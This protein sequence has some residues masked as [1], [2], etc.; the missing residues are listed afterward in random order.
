MSS[1]KK[2][3]KKTAKGK[4]KKAAK[5]SPG[6]EALLPDGVELPE[7]FDLDDA[8]L[9]SL[10]EG[11]GLANILDAAFDAPEN[12]RDAVLGDVDFD[13]LAPDGQ[14]LVL[15][16]E[17]FDKT[18][19]N[20]GWDFQGEAA[21]AGM[22]LWEFPP[23]VDK[24]FEG[25][26]DEAPMTMLALAIPEQ[27]VPSEQL[28][29]SVSLVGEDPQLP[30]VALL[31]DV[32]KHIRDI[33]HFRVGGDVSVFPFERLQLTVRELVGQAIATGNTDLLPPEAGPVFNRL[34]EF[35]MGL[36]KRGWALD[37]DQVEYGQF[38]WFYAPS[39]TGDDDPNIAPVTAF[40]LDL[41]DDGQGEIA[42]MGGILDWAGG[43]L[44][45][46][47]DVPVRV[48]RANLDAVEKHRAGDP[49]PELPRG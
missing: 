18:L 10:L 47:E 49:E 27:I 5:P 42:D 34:R 12:V 21:Y 7:N 40:E 39:D 26:A 8:T 14:E 15:G 20:R 13:D 17:R 29:L 4:D 30:F 3:A 24:G 22:L 1:K 6:G 43:E 46:P 2:A 16:L 28:E 48:L 41:P 35:S 31:G 19:K 11:M 37:G 25:D 23:S 44:E 9:D 33:E 38:V 32:I 36:E 45:H